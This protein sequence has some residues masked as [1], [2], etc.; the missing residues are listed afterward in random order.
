MRKEML[1]E[2]TSVFPARSTGN[3]TGA[4]PMNPLTVMGSS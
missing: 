4:V 3:E 2:E 1:L